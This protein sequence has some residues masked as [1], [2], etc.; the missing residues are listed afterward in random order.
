LPTLAHINVLS[1]WEVAHYWH[2]LDP[3]KGKSH[4]LPLQVRNTILVLTEWF[5]NNIAYRVD[6]N[7]PHLLP[8]VQK[9]PRF[10]ARYYRHRIRK[11]VETKN[12]SK[13]FFNKIYIARSEL[14]QRCITHNESLPPFW[15]PDNE[16][17][18]FLSKG[19]TSKE[20][21]DNGRYVLVPIFNDGNH[22]SDQISEPS[23][24]TATV[25]SN[26]TKA[27]N[28]KHAPMNA[29]KADFIAAYERIP[30]GQVNRTALAREFFDSLEDKKKLLFD[31][32]DA[33][34]RTLTTA[35]REHLRD[36]SP[37]S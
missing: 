7:K 35:L 8:I 32:K 36:S 24:P 23:Q 14:A 9:Q 5:C 1:I 21:A 19:D 17:F 10:T 20:L 28:K 26:A 33:A 16:K 31:N 29:I 34:I 25:S 27:A 13:K 6:S 2:D 30:D 4:Q 12:F 3:R 11:A 37:S 18:P 22:Q 15:F